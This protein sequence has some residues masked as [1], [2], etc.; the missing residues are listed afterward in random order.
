MGCYLFVQQSPWD[1]LNSEAKKGDASAQSA[2]GFLYDK[3]Q[4]YSQAAQWWRKAAAQ[5][6]RLAQFGLGNLYLY[7]QGGVPQ[8]ASQAAQW[9]LKAAAQG[10]DG[11]Q[12]MM[13][14]FY[15]DGVGVPQDYGQAAQWYRKAA[16]Q[17]NRLAQ[18]YLG[19]LYVKGQGVSRN[20]V[21]AYALFNLSSTQE[22]AGSDHTASENRSKTANLMSKQEIEAGQALSRKMSA[23]GQLLKALD[24]YMST[25]K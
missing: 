24:E 4:D 8:D 9:Y 16:A 22:S 17:G 10:Y 5:G 2:L 1:T 14:T 20:Y 21:A 6:N 18:Y 19:L 11:A 15:D 23:P 7:G 25:S 12:A 13:G 3:A